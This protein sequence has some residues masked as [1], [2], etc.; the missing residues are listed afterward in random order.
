MSAT[1]ITNTEGGT[2]CGRTGIRGR[3][4]E[5]EFQS[6]Q[7]Q[8]KARKRTKTRADHACALRDTK[9][10]YTIIGSRREDLN[11][12]VTRT[13]IAGLCAACRQRASV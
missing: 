7:A 11:C 12:P 3:V 5:A 10:C 6:L 9:G 2:L 13:T 1:H 8:G 4:S